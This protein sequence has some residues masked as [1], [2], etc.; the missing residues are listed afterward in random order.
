MI[1]ARQKDRS[2]PLAEGERAMKTVIVVS[3]FA[4]A[5]SALYSGCGTAGGERVPPARSN[6]LS[7]DEIESV[8]ARNMYEVIE[9]LRPRWLIVRRGTRSIQEE[10]SILVYQEN[11]RLGTI[12]VLRQISPDMVRS[13][14][15][16]DGIKA[17][18]ILPG[19]GSGHVA[20]AIVIT[21]VTRQY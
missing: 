17:M 16:I 11:L 7:R 18:S 6:E 5:L 21:P 20:G 2:V 10:P 12:E 15:Y 13:V 19:I 4:F 8:N 14:E 1:S 9:Q 3:M